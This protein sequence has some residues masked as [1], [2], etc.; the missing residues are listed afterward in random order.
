MADLPRI[1]FYLVSFVD[2]LLVSVQ[3]ALN[4][5]ITSEFGTHGLLT[6]VGIISTILS[7]STKL[8]LAKIADI[9]GR[10][11][12]FTFM[13][14]VVLIGL[15]MKATC[16]S[17]EVYVAAHTFYWVGHIGMLYVV[18]VVLADITS[19]RNRMTIFGIM[20]TPLIAS[21]FA[22]P[23]IAERFYEDLNFRWAFGA[24]TII[25]LGVCLPVMVVLFME[26]RRAKKAGLITS[27]PSGR[28]S[29]ETFKYY[30]TEFDGVSPSPRKVK[31]C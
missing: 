2:Q 7:G 11:E 19:L 20:G 17:I 25:L 31:S 1:R 10:L 23:A 29:F 30:A 15:I 24:F 13:L 9:F 3:G 12:A 18:D 5:F 21:T 27:R 16:Q 14:I 28:T 8:T 4:P 6:S 22:G 26:S